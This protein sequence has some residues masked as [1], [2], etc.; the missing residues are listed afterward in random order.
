MQQVS[1]PGKLAVCTCYFNPCKWASRRRN[2]EL[3]LG[4]ILSQGADL[5]VATTESP[6]ELPERNDVHIVRFGAKGAIWQKERLLNLLIQ[7]LPDEYDKVVWTD[8]DILYDSPSWLYD[9]SE[10]L[11]EHKTCQCFSEAIWLNQMYVPQSWFKDNPVPQTWFDI[12]AGKVFR[13]SM[14]RHLRN[15]GNINFH[16]AHPGFSWAARRSVL[17]EIGG[18]YDGHILGSGDT[19]M[20]MTFCGAIDH[21]YFNILGGVFK[22]HCT[23]W[24]VKANEVVQGDAW[25]VF[26]SIR[27]LWHGKLEDRQYEERVFKLAR[28]GF[29]PD[30]H[31]ITTPSGLWGLSSETP[32]VVR[33]FINSYFKTR[34]ED[35]KGQRS[36]FRPITSYVTLPGKT[37][38]CACY[39]NPCDWLS[40]RVNYKMFVDSILEQGADLWVATT[41]TSQELPEMEGVHVVRFDS[42]SFI[43]QKER[44]LNL[45]IGKLPPEYDKIVWTDCDILY[46]SPTWLSDVIRALEKYKICQCFSEA[47]WLNEHFYSEI[48]YPHHPMVYRLSVPKHI[49]NGGEMSFCHSHPGFSWAARRE[50]ILQMGG[51]YDGH[52]SGSGDSIMVLGFYGL[53]KYYDFGGSFKNHI[54]RW[55]HKAYEAVGE[56]ISYVPGLIKHLWHGGRPDRNYDTELKALIQLGFDIEKHVVSDNNGLWT[57]S[58]SA[59]ETVKRYMKTYLMNRREDGSGEEPTV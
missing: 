18:L 22:E 17:K 12:K 35:G 45:L 23:K 42:K 11:H 44:L 27:H 19:I 52:L 59:P 57:W 29:D 21:P 26:G 53:F 10:V 20:A 16:Y 39:Y 49:E 40:R 46:D 14:S 47:V 6:E 8:C 1:L 9:V 31:L 58:P 50:T 2:Y 34:K 15:G 25:H 36:H 24:A 7:Q 32:V 30:K 4:A 54:S 51:L 33:N 43:W 55:Y 5:W 41:E 37:A 38:V 48:W 13:P 3:F 28:L 56:S